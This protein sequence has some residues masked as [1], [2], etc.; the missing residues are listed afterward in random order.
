MKKALLLFALGLQ[1]MAA[2]SV[3]S[4]E[5]I[6]TKVANA[7]RSAQKYLIVANAGM[8]FPGGTQPKSVKVTLAVELPD[9]I[10]LEGDG[11]AL[12]LG[13]FN[14]PVAIVSDGDAIWISDTASKKHYKKPRTSAKGTVGT[15]DGSEPSLDH[16]EQFVATYHYFNNANYQ[17]LLDKRRSSTV[18]GTETLSRDGG[19][20]ECYVVQ[21]DRGAYAEKKA[22]SDRHTVWVDQRT[23]VVWKEIRS[24]FRG[25]G[26]EER[27][28]TDMTTVILNGS[29]PKDVFVFQ[30]TPG[31]TLAALPQ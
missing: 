27:T 28:V 7:Y 22:G 23:Y 1:L 10:R 8:E 30:P 29:L 3:P 2:Q 11:S 5:E 13:G 19:S 16:P 24:T 21:S 26:V 20:V 12:R 31:S 15:V 18:T 6:L 4:A 14:G 17:S 9:K 25:N